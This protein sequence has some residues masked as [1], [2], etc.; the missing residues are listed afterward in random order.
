MLFFQQTKPVDNHRQ[1]SGFIDQKPG[2]H[3][4]PSG[5]SR[6]NQKCNDRQRNDD[7]LTDI[8]DG[9]PAESKDYRKL[10]QIV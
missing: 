5:Q 4:D 6:G 8:P 9:S 10:R 3:P 1:T 2:D 7:V